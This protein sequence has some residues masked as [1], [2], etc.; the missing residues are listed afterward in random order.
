MPIQY[1]MSTRAKKR[2]LCAP[3]H[4]IMKILFAENE[5]IVKVKSL[6]SLLFQKRHQYGISVLVVKDCL[7]S[8]LQLLQ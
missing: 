6:K 8:V 7:K 2:D 4:E 5:K 3:L 1:A